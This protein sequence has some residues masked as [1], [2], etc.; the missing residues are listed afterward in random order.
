MLTIRNGAIFRP[1]TASV[2]RGGYFDF[3]DGYTLIQVG[4]GGSSGCSLYY[5]PHIELGGKMSGNL[6]VSSGSV[7]N[8]YPFFSGSGVLYKSYS[9]SY[10]NIVTAKGTEPFY[11]RCPDDNSPCGFYRGSGLPGAGSIVT[12]NDI[13][14]G[15][16]VTLK[17]AGVGYRYVGSGATGGVDFCSGTLVPYAGLYSKAF[18]TGYGKPQKLLLGCPVFQFP[19]YKS[20][21]SDP[22]WNLTKLYGYNLSKMKVGTISHGRYGDGGFSVEFAVDETN[23]YRLVKKNDY[24]APYGLEFGEFCRFVFDSTTIS[25]DEAASGSKILSGKFYERMEYVE[26]DLPTGKTEG[27]SR[28]KYVRAKLTKNVDGYDVT[29]EFIEEGNKSHYISVGQITLGGTRKFHVVVEGGKPAYALFGMNSGARIYKLDSSRK[30]MKENKDGRVYRGV[31]RDRN[32]T[33]MKDFDVSGIK[34]VGFSFYNPN[35]GE[36]L[37]AAFSMAWR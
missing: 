21:L 35:N 18:D 6:E 23:G 22:M 1:D 7:Y 8:G 32:F 29:S 17:G 20:G 24:Y 12:Y 19:E 26:L 31:T 10:D 28:K 33:H 34:Q 36:K 2:Y 9:D 30:M 14:S 15:D 5:K 25:K 13:V 11:S 37:S 16:A 4:R 27:T 3:G